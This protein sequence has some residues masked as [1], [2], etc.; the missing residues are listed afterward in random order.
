MKFKVF[1]MA[2]LASIISIKLASNFHINNLKKEISTLREFLKPFNRDIF[3]Q[4]PREINIEV[5]IVMIFMSR[6]IF[7]SEFS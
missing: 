6:E 4:F 7:G 3:P 1:Q 5:N 2:R